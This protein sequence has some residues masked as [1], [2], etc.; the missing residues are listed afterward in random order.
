MSTITLVSDASTARVVD[1]AAVVLVMPAA[2]RRQQLLSAL[3]GLNARVVR[4]GAGYPQNAEVEE[5][6]EMDC[7]AFL[8]DLDSQPEQALNLI[9]ILGSRASAATVMACSTN[10]ESALLLRA[11]R[12]GAR[13]FLTEPVPHQVLGEALARAC[14]RREK[15]RHQKPAARLLVFTGAKGGSG[16][17]MLATNFAVA[18]TQQG[19]GKVVVVD[20]DAETGEVA[21]GL[22]L[23]PQFSILDAVQNQ[24]RLD[25]DFLQSLLAKHTSGLA[26]LASPEQYAPAHQIAGELLKMFRILREQFA[27]VVVDAGPIGSSVQEVVLDLADVLYLV[28]ETS[29][30]ALRNARR[31]L[32]FIAGRERSPRVEVVLNRF[33]ARDVQIDENAAAKALA[34]PVDW[35]IPNDFAAVRSAENTGIPL[36]MKDSPISRVLGRMAQAACGR[37]AGP[38]KKSRNLLR[39]FE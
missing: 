3:A 29:I 8:V 12:A 1:S 23:T 15:R 24:D 6:L 27:F 16:T 11:M 36:A 5:L 31:L 10:A 25:A 17:T 4:A 35:K 18:L 26:V 32:S 21:L 7:D 34:R 30:P 38:E 14:A 9:E 13:E 2:V 20:A 39:I 28:T 37:P 19:A 33:N 22:G